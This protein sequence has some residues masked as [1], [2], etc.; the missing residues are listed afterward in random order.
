MIRF[1]KLTKYWAKNFARF[2]FDY[3]GHF[4]LKEPQNSVPQKKRLTK[5]NIH[6]KI[7]N[8]EMKKKKRM[9][10]KIMKNF[11]CVLMFFNMVLICHAIFT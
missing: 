5:S 2:S 9:C 4:R 11:L 6:E 8:C 10:F 7:K 1:V 3:F